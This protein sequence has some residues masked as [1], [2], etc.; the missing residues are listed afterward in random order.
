MCELYDLG[1]REVSKIN[2]PNGI[3]YKDHS[4][5]GYYICICDKDD[6]KYPTFSYVGYFIKCEQTF[7]LNNL[8]KESVL[9]IENGEIVD[10]IYKIFTNRKDDI[11]E[12]MLNELGIFY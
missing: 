6:T 3:Y 1:F 11:R 10:N 8:V 2:L 9:I 5:E 7:Y 4:I 12:Q